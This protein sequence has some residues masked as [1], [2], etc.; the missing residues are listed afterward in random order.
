MEVMD[1]L[2]R[3]SLRNILASGKRAD[4][5]KMNDYRDYSVSRGVLPNAEG[6]ALARI[7]NSKVLAGIKF[8]VATPFADR[9]TQGVLSTNAELL[10]LASHLFEPGPPGEN[11]IELARVVDR[12][13]RSSEA[14]DLDSFFIEA[15]KVLALYIDLYVLD[16]D[17]NLID[18]AALAALGA[19]ASARVPKVESAKVVR[20]EFAGKLDLRAKAVACTYLKVDSHC[21]LD[22]TLDEEAGSDARLTITTTEEGKVCAAQKGGWGAFTK[23]E[24]GSMI[25]ISFEQGARLRAA[26]LAE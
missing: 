25:D 1:E 9:P 2:K 5:R 14:I 26:A 11:A 20:G 4:G 3:D 19:L 24:I 8:D 13:I 7:G 15:G 22:A 21:L 18:T 17:G 16:H 12:G 23:S 10:P 6:S